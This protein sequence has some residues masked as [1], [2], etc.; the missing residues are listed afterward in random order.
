LEEGLTELVRWIKTHG[1]A[2]R[3]FFEKG[4]NELRERK[5]AT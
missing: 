5:L 2:A 4:L 3:G 1:W